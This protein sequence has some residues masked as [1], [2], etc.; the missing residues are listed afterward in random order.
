M[1]LLRSLFIICTLIFSAN[2]GISQSA[3]NPDNK[4][5]IVLDIQEGYINKVSNDETINK[6]INSVNQVIEHSDADKITYV[7]TLHKA[8]VVSTKGIHIDTISKLEMDSRVKTVNNNLFVKDNVNAFTV[9]EL[10][11]FL[12]KNNA[13]EIV[14][15]GLVAEECVYNTLIGGKEKGYNMYVIPEAILSKSEKKKEKTI[16]KLAE[17]GINN[18]TIKEYCTAAK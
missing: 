18:L 3:S 5:V 2:Y 4:F 8:I 17:K 16:R 6:F 14:V 11:C 13:K 10:V 9:D 12:E 7:V 15:V 1:K